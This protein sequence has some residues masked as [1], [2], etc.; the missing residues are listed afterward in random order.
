MGSWN[1]TRCQDIKSFLFGTDRTSLDIHKY[2]PCDYSS[3]PAD[4]LY[5]YSDSSDI[6]FRLQPGGTYRP[7]PTFAYRTPPLHSWGE[8]INHAGTV[9]HR[10]T[11][12]YQRLDYPVNLQW[13]EVS[14][15]NCHSLVGTMQQRTCGELLLPGLASNISALGPYTHGSPF[16]ASCY[17]GPDS[18]YG[19]INSTEICGGTGNWGPTYVEVWRLETTVWH[20]YV[21]ACH[22][23]TKLQS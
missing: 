8:A 23:H 22:N 12:V 21:F 17:G 18:I 9:T 1:W 3:M 13:G 10:V 2:L 7:S 19:A 11:D 16:V 20:R 15:S 4:F 5:R 14:D 6:I